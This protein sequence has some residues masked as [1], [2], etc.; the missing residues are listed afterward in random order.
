MKRLALL[1]IILSVIFLYVPLSTYAN[2]EEQSTGAKIGSKFSRGVVNTA[3]GLVVDWPKTIYY[4]TKKKGPAYGLTIG[5]FKGIGVGVGRTLIGAY[6]LVT[7]PLPYP[8]D[9][10]PI[11]SPDYP[12]Q[13]G[14]TT[15]R[16]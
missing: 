1:T 13:P 5:L 16:E 9:Y 14:E 3:F 2:A 10:T 8:E 15:R 11:L 7:F 6:E 12:F 4:D